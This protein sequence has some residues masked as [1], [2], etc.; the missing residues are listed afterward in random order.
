MY[1]T[2]KTEM[3]PAERRI[4]EHM[5]AAVRVCHESYKTGQA[6]GSDV[7]RYF[8]FLKSRPA[9]RDQSSEAKVRAYLTDLAPHV[10]AKT[11]NQHLCAIKRYY[12]QVL[13]RP[14]GDLGQWAYAKR[15]QRAPVWLN[16]GEVQRLLACLSG[17]HALMAQVC[18][19]SGLRLMEMVRLRQ[20]HVDLER[21]TLFILG[22]KGDK[23]RVVPL[24][25]A[26]VAPLAEHIQRVRALWQG[27][28]ANGFP[29]VQLPDGLERKYP[30]AGHEW[31]WYWVWPGRNLSTDPE[32]KIVRRHHTHEN[33]FQKAIKAAAQRAG[34]GK[35][36]KVHTLRHSFATHCLENGMPVTT[37]QRLLGHA[38]LET[39]SIYLHCLPHLIEQAASPLDT[40]P[41]QMLEFPRG[42]T[43][44]LDNYTEGRRAVQ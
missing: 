42:E 19:G 28:L 9:L 10:A 2:A 35:R 23:D 13:R 17:T 32:T 37:L 1:Y 31:C 22:G 24:A 3:T 6:Y 30:N 5:I 43:Y 44:K 36:V 16:P 29:P 33:G 34:I 26:C 20:Q 8:R 38:H 12:E 15:P 7:V 14:L 27:D 11:Q 21:R 39:T 40:L 4:Y 41:G 18:Y 25:R